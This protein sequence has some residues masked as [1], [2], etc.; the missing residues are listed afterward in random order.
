MK[1]TSKILLCFLLL[2]ARNLLAQNTTHFRADRQ[3]LTWQGDPSTTMTVQWLA[4][5]PM[6]PLHPAEPEILPLPAIPRLLLAEPLGNADALRQDGLQV[7]ALFNEYDLMWHEAESPFSAEAR[8]GWSDLGLHLL[9]RVLDPARSVDENPNRFWTGDSVEVILS[10][11]VGSTNRLKLNATPGTHGEE[12]RHFFSQ[13]RGEWDRDALQAQSRSMDLDDGYAL[14]FFFAWEHLPDL[15]GEVGRPLGLQLLVNS[16]VD[17]ET[18]VRRISLHPNPVTLRDPYAAYAFVLAEE[19]SDPVRFRSNLVEENGFAPVARL[20]VPP[21]EDNPTV[22]LR[23]ENFRIAETQFEKKPGGSRV[24]EVALSHAP[25]Q[26]RWNTLTWYVDGEAV[27]NIQPP[28]SLNY[29]PVHDGRQVNL[30]VWEASAGEAAADVRAV[31]PV[32]VHQWPGKQLYRVELTGLKP[33][34]AYRYRVEGEPLD[35]GFRTLP[36]TLDEPLRFAIGGDTRHR[37]AWMEATNRVVMSYNPAFIVWGG[38]FAYADGEEQNLYRWREWFDANTNTLIDENRFITPILGVVGNHEVVRGY[39]FRHPEYEQTD[40]WRLR[41]APY[42]N[43]LFAFPGPQGWG[44][45]DIGDQ[46]SFLFLDSDHTNPVDGTQ[47]GWLEEA[48]RTRRDRKH[49][50]PV[51]HV[52]A[53]PSA[54]PFTDRTSIKI[55]EHWVPLFE[56]HGVRVSFENHDH[57]YKRTHPLRGGEIDPEN[58][59]LY[60]GDGA[61]GVNT[62]QKNPDNAWYLD[63]FES[64]RHGIVVTLHADRQEFLVVSE[65]GDVLDT[66]LVD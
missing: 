20:V 63:R 42:F 11:Q 6:L 5:L 32:R 35:F 48:L 38:D 14:E 34:T 59:I 26:T 43:Q 17:A 25:D 30:H 65:D 29:P 31:L 64:K 15:G 47:T 57:T 56:E 44:A 54:R 18:P 33:G 13:P 1:F 51:Y 60:V 4:D 23:Q 53:Y 55:R 27:G 41:I 46:V 7:T 10:E 45:I 66:F 50:F 61:W 39:Y 58:G 22:E 37:Q 21:G 36:D 2:C 3:L 40:E 49:V 16:R 62:R 12:G 19:A 9:V 24:A 28:D 8:L 52:T